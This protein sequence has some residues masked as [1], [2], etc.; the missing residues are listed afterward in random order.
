MIMEESVEREFDRLWKCQEKMDEKLDK[1]LEQVTNS[2][3]KVAAIAAL[4]GF[5]G[6]AVPVI[7][8]IVL[9]VIG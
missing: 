4:L 2:R 3:I 9:K 8:T 6:G 1:I 7:V 5:I